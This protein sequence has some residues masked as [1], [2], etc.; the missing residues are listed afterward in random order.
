MF[1]VGRGRGSVR[2][3]SGPGCEESPARAG[4]PLGT[5]TFRVCK[6]K[7][8]GDFSATHWLGSV[9]GGPWKDLDL[10]AGAL[11]EISL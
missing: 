6:D 3:R 10:K 2:L 8:H 7:R 4:T 5:E 11:L 1:G 9:Q